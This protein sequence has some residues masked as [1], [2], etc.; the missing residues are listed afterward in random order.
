MRNITHKQIIENQLIARQTLEAEQLVGYWIT[1][2]GISRK[3]LLSH[4]QF[5]DLLLLIRWREQFYET[6]KTKHRKFF[7]NTWRWVYNNQFAL[8]AKQ[9]RT[10]YYYA[11]A[12]IKHQHNVSVREQAQREKI[13]IRRNYRKALE[14]QS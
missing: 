9:L 10:L 8:K 6:G 3:D 7:D 12:G 4:P 14:A 11:Q 2:Y 1:R 13:Q 5:D